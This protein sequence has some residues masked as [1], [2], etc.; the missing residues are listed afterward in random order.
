M[1]I[2]VSGT[3]NVGKSTLI[4]DFIAKWGKYI[5]PPS[6]YRDIINNHKDNHSSNT[7][8]DVQDKILDFMINTQSQY[9]SKDNV[10]FDRCALDNLVYTLWC[11]HKDKIPSHYADSII[12]RVRESL[13]DID[14]IFIIRHDPSITIV[15]DGTRDTNI[16]YIREIDAIFGLL[17]EEYLKFDENTFKIFPKDDMPA[18]IEI[19]GSKE[20]RISQ[21]SDYIDPFGEAVDTS[22]TESVLSLDHVE[23]MEKL[24]K[25]QE[26]I[27]L[28][29][30]WGIN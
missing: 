20:Q 4:D 9:T 22:P 17:I 6:S 3:S 26:R 13:K 14:I 16:E 24:V 12:P 10:I 28:E 5:T 2:A 8:Q 15:D 29:Q 23:E 25:I 30:K 19:S 27:S 21:I 18:L 7:S 11:V 1:R